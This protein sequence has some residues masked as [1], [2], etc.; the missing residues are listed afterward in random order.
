MLHLEYLKK[1]YKGCRIHIEPEK[2]T[3]IPR[4]RHYCMHGFVVENPVR[5]FSRKMRSGEYDGVPEERV[6]EEA[7]V[8]NL[9]S[10]L[11]DGEGCE[12]ILILFSRVLQEYCNLKLGRDVFACS[13]CEEPQWTEEDFRLCEE[14]D[15]VP[16]EW[17]EDEKEEDKKNEEEKHEEKEN[18][19]PDRKKK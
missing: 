7:E 4:L 5:I 3:L 17:T 16:E 19:K 14:A 12:N 18:D 8:A 2:E 6:A 1:D 11:W 10:D 9:L 15:E 13:D